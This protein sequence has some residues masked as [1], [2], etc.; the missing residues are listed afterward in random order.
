MES[1]DT[2]HASSSSSEARVLIDHV[3]ASSGVFSSSPYK[4]LN[5]VKPVD[6]ETTV[7]DSTPLLLIHPTTFPLAD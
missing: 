1:F 6:L 5:G 2:L 4:S 7:Y 3:F